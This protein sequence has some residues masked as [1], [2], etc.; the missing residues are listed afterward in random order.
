M[1]C[2][3]SVSSG[4]SMSIEKWTYFLATIDAYCYNDRHSLPPLYSQFNYYL[5]HI[6]SSAA[7]SSLSAFKQTVLHFL[8]LFV[9]VFLLCSYLHVS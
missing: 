3:V 9:L 7:N 6:I 1:T 8:Y 2:H 4:Y 5:L